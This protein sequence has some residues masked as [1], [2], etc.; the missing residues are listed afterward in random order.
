MNTKVVGGHRRRGLPS[1][2]LATM[3]AVAATLVCFCVA[4][5]ATAFAQAAIAG[6]VKD[7]S[8]GVLPDVTVEATSPA[9]IEKTRSATT[10]SSGQY[11]IENL[12]PGIYTVSFT[13]PGLAT[14]RQQGIELT[15]SL[16][17]TVNAELR[18][19][20]LAEAIVVSGANSIVDVY[21]SHRET[22]LT[23]EVVKSIPTARTYNALLVLVPGIVT[24]VNDTVTSPA[25][26]AFP[27][28]GGRS[29]EGRLWLDG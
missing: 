25:T 18:I 22:S 29:T 15:G 16:T 24:S 10:D 20:P 19:G 12:T 28:H 3:P 8:G 9:L 13:R 26:I 27:M 17:V 4:V 11:R 7:T 6:T 21:S 2:T 1:P 5:P 14:E 23:T